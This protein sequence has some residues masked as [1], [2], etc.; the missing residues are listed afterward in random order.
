MCPTPSSAPVSYLGIAWLL[1]ADAPEGV[2]AGGFDVVCL[3]GRGD[4]DMSE[5]LARLQA[6]DG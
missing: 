6:L 1:E 4:K 5:A 3:S 2:P